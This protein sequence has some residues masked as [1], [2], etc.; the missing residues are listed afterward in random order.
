MKRLLLFF[1]SIFY[2]LLASAEIL[3]PVKW[4]HSV[5]NQADDGSIVV[6]FV[7]KIDAGW[8]VYDLNMPD[9]GPVSTSVE[10]DVLDNIKPKGSVK[11]TTKPI[12]KA[13][14]AFGGMVLRFYE[15]TLTLNQTLT[16]NDRS[17]KSTV[18][19]SLR[20]M[21]CDDQQCLPPSGY[22]FKFDVQPSAAVVPSKMKN[23]VVANVVEDANQTDA[24]KS[25]AKFNIAEIES[26]NAEFSSDKKQSQELYS[27]SI[28]ELQSFGVSEEGAD[29]SAS[30][31]R[32]FLSGVLGGLIAIVTPCVWPIIPM[33]VSF[34]LKRS[35]KERQKSADGKVVMSGKKQAFL[36]GLSI[37]VIYVFLGL[38]I[39]WLFGASALNTLSTDPFFNLFM[40]FLLVFFACSFFGG[41]D[42]TL[43]ASWSTAIDE[44]AD[45]SSGL[46]AIMLMACTLVIV[47]FSCTG[48]IIGTVL[49]N[50]STEGVI[51]GPVLCMFGFALAL[52]L[53]F[54]FFA[55]FPSI[56]KS[57]PRSGSWLNTV[58]VLLGFFELAFSLKFLSVA[59]QT[60][61]G[62]D[63]LS[64]Q[65]FIAIW[66][67]LFILCGVYLLGKLRLPHDDEV[68][69]VSVPRFLLAIGSFAFAVYM[70]PGLFGAPLNVISAFA[71]PAKQTDASLYT[72]TVHAQYSDYD[73]AL[74]VA[75]REKKPLILDFTGFGCVNCRKMESAVW[76]DPEVSEI[77]N[78][79]Y[80][81]VSLFVDDRTPLADT[82]Y[83]NEGDK[84]IKLTTVGEK[85]S[86]LQRHKFGANAQPFYVLMNH[87]G[88]IL[89]HSFA[90]S[91][92]PKAFSEFLKQGLNIK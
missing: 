14:P 33:T 54:T 36:Y 11:S 63:L 69:V 64:R 13:E 21:C 73:L 53:P 20:F 16:V 84:Q 10:F 68:E 71:P 85:W 66:I 46:I 12:E 74:S 41:F 15:N 17:K 78:N 29:K 57:L 8:H 91:E 50:V 90:F 9:D 88:R 6:T 18:A 4:T 79:D 43:P 58:K 35:E 27:S 51:L 62:W 3:E 65:T 23:Q 32:L 61:Y 76:T 26:N 42:L 34:F 25:D 56:L 5:S 59:D 38:I 80:I 49:V 82:L 48:P 7:A 72:K 70:I 39:T 2:T 86:Y 77:I 22:V 60:A 1:I 89:N 45:K 67:V 87:D 19:G 37:I 31:L 40:F 24:S 81:L 75:S 30:L 44:K 83:V 47:S 52:S 55:F 92:D 28:Q